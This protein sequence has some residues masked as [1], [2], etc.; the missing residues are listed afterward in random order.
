MVINLSLFF[1]V[2]HNTAQSRDQRDKPPSSLFGGCN[3]QNIWK[4]NLYELGI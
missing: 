3:Q 4:L 1:T 2:D